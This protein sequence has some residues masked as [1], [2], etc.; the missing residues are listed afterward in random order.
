MQFVFRHISD[1]E[2]AAPNPGEL[3]IGSSCNAPVAGRAFAELALKEGLSAFPQG[4][5][6]IK[7][8]IVSADPTLDDLLAAEFVGL[9]LGGKELPAGARAFADYAWAIRRG[10]KPDPL[11]V[12]LDCSL[13]GVFQAMRRGVG[14]DLSL[15]EAADKF[16]MKWSS[17]ASRILAAAQEGLDPTITAF[18]VQG[19][20]FVQERDSLRR[21]HDVFRQDVHRGVEWSVKIPTTNGRC[22]GYGLLLRDPKSKFFKYW[23]RDLQS[24]LKAEPYSLLAA[25]EGATRWTF[26]TDPVL[27][28]S[29]IG[30]HEK[31][32]TAEAAANPQRAAQDPWYNGARH[33]Y[34]L[35]ASPKS[36]TVLPE[37]I[38]LG[39]VR[40]W[41]QTKPLGKVRSLPKPLMIGV[42]AA[43]MVGLALYWQGHSLFGR[44]S[45]A[46]IAPGEP[47]GK[48]VERDMPTHQ[49]Q[50]NI[51][52][53][54]GKP[55]AT[56]FTPYNPSKSVQPVSLN[57][58]LL[59]N[60]NGVSVP[61]GA[62]F[63]S[64]E[65]T[66]NGKP[67]VIDPKQLV[68]KPDELVLDHLK[69]SFNRG[70]NSVIVTALDAKRATES[71]TATLDWSFDAGRLPNLYVLTIGIS[72]YKVPQYQLNYASDDA[73]SLTEAFANDEGLLFGK[74]KVRQLLNEEAQRDRIIS[75]LFELQEATQDD[76]VIVC[77][78]GHGAKG[79]GER[80]YLLPWEWDCQDESHCNSDLVSKAVSWE[81]D[82]LAPLGALPCQVLVLLDTCH[83]GAA[84][85]TKGLE[86]EE[87]KNVIQDAVQ[88]KRRNSPGIVL[89]AA[90]L[91]DQVANEK[92]EW[93]HGVCTLA[94]LE[95]LQ[96]QI[97]DGLS[98]T[99][100]LPRG[101]VV[102]LQD[103]SSYVSARVRDLTGG[104]QAVITNTFRAAIS[105]EDIPITLHEPTTIE[106][107]GK[108]GG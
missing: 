28:L 25:K 68:G 53:E 48:L 80:F 42:A 1:Q 3:L 4:A 98:V 58:H 31:L 72:K 5:V 79:N 2:I 82:F 35:V 49:E 23:S 96:G 29:L 99:Q 84:V 20:E 105:L 59:A 40:E 12:P 87:F 66:V 77:V 107:T 106:Q 56:L 67:I 22:D 73:V 60:A 21:D 103:L 92:A 95:G 75:A 76:L 86:P 47:V 104:R 102:N 8:I 101:E 41:G 93:G 94:F 9:L 45:A 30:L 63:P 62:P 10:Y 18:R 17:L 69:T 89:M 46:T 26:S 74:V 32:Q 52:F 100:S 51:H 27:E 6:P 83:S 11:E 65:V 91:P 71:W 88:R 34:T 70:E 14:P 36:G 16:N 50:H 19:S 38:I 7:R 54:R 13:E 57:V 108:N 81:E 97:H 33:Q 24:H 64:V 61:T 55:S 78:S 39:V 15:S 43:L 90:C 85:G 37:Q 44:G